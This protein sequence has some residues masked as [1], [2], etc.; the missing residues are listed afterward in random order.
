[1]GS[2]TGS[3]QSS[4]CPDCN[5]AAVIHLKGAINQFVT[6]SHLCIIPENILSQKIFCVAIFED[7]LFKRFSFIAPKTLLTFPSPCLEV[8]LLLKIFQ[9][10]RE[11]IMDRTTGKIQNI[12]QTIF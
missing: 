1:M 2:N 6:G 11:L 10:P 4:F 12:K 7:V 3:Y 5:T 9:Y 8:L